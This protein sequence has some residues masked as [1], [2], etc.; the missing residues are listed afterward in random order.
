[1]VMVVVVVTDPEPAEQML[2]PPPQTSEVVAH[3]TAFQKDEE[4]PCA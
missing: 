2:D 3:G 1:V 4:V